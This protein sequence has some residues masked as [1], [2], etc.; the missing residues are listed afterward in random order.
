MISQKITNVSTQQ[1]R[2]AKIVRQTKGAVIK[3][4]NHYLTEEWLITAYQLVNRK[5]ASGI[6][7][8]S[9]EDFEMEM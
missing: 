8:M 9:S 7:N 5:A 3:S 2:I 4:L 1:E 6:D